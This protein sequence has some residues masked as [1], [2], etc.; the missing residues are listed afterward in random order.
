MAKGD[1]LFWQWE[2]IR[3][4]QAHRFGISTEELTA[5]LECNTRTVQRDLNVLQDIFPISHEQ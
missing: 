3:A 1:R 2:L 5:R 4:L